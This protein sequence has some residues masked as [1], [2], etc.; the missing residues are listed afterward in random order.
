METKLSSFSNT[1][2]KDLLASGFVFSHLHTY[3]LYMPDICV[4]FEPYPSFT[5]FMTIMGNSVGFETM[6]RNLSQMKLAR[7]WTHINDN[8]ISVHYI[9]LRTRMVSI[10]KP[11]VLG[12]EENLMPYVIRIAM[13]R[14]NDRIAIGRC[15]Y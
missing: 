7:R 3:G 15:T 13:G 6:N 9:F 11:Q 2:T 10:K 1:C 5:S 12:A 4:L 8:I 14:F